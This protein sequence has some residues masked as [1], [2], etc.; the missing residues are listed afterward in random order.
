MRY[1][2]IIFSP[3]SVMKSFF[4]KTFALVS[5]CATSASALSLY[6]TA[7]MVG[8]AESQSAQ[9]FAT[10]NFGYDTNPRSTSDSANKKG[11]CYVNASLSSTFADVESVNHFSYNVRLGATRYLGESSSD[12]R[13][14]YGD[15]AVDVSY[16]HAFSSASRYSGRLH[17]SYMPEPGYDNGMSSAGMTG[18]T[19][20]WSLNNMYSQAIDARWSWNVG[21]NVSGTHYMESSYAYDDRQYY[22]AS[23]GLNYRASDRLTYTSSL[24]CRWEER[25]YGAASRSMFANVGI[26]YALDPVSS[27]T[28]SVGAQCKTMTGATDMNP[29]LN[30]GYRR[31][32]SDGLSMN[33]YISYSDENTNNYSRAARSS[34]RSC[35]SWRAGLYGTYVVSPDVS[36]VFG[37]QLMYTDYSKGGRGMQSGKRLTVKP[38]LSMNY[39]FSPQLQGSVGVEYTY[40]TYSQ[41]NNHNLDYTRWRLWTGMTY[42]F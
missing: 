37:P 1:R 5:I 16:E 20:S 36:F 42:R 33:S 35:G 3:L 13:K 41:T 19:L 39:S 38:S 17:V 10:V 30:V 12:G 6:D 22:S 40:N 14:Y 27:M 28:V 24:S 8:F 29:T 32:V 18:D 31:R 34:Y 11:Q 4:L 2:I 15:C 25:T 9:Y 26:Q 7:P 21:F 23:A